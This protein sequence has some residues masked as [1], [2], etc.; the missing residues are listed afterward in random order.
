MPASLRVT[1]RPGRQRNP[2]LPFQH[3]EAVAAAEGAVWLIRPAA[4]LASD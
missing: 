4:S 3:P 2:W 1:R